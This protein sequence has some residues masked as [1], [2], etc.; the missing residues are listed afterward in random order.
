MEDNDFVRGNWLRE[1]ASSSKEMEPEPSGI[2]E[3]LVASSPELVRY[4][5]CVI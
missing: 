5:N 3:E 1:D 2:L 4:V